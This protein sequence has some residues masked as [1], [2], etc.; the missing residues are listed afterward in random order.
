METG[1]QAAAE[2]SDR[3][4]SCLG[5][6]LRARKEEDTLALLVLNM[7]EHVDTF[8]PPRSGAQEVHG[9]DERGLKPPGGA[10]APPGDTEGGGGGD[11][12]VCVACS[13]A[14]VCVQRPGQTGKAALRHHPQLWKTDKRG[15][16]EVV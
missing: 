4:P 8:H 11:P 12:R 1:W 3:L 2:A 5:E 6:R 14:V 9:G 16:M 7:P 13:Q 10:R 15:E